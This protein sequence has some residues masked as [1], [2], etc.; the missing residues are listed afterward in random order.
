MLK[1]GGSITL[2]KDHKTAAKDADAIATDVWVS[3]GEDPSVWGQRIKDLTPYQVTMEK[4]KQAKED[5]IF[6]HCLP[7]FHDAET[8]IAQQVIK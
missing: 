7:S 1:N 2:T 4:M 5:V 6:L 8:D 3:M